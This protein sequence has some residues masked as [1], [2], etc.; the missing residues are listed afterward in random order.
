M[1]IEQLEQLK[2]KIET[3]EVDSF[4]HWKSWERLRKQV[5]AMDHWEC[6]RCKEKGKYQKA[7]VVHHV[8]HLKDRPDLALSVYDN[9]GRRNL[10]SLCKACHEMEHPERMQIYNGRTAQ[11]VTDERWD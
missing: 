2:K 1:Q 9:N 7:R 4:Y 8:N 3:D 11:P 5:L 6:V 10:V